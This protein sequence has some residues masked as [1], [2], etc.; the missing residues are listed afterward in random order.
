M[1]EVIL[2]GSS[3]P[4]RRVWFAAIASWLG[5]AQPR[6]GVMTKRRRGCAEDAPRGTA[7]DGLDEEMSYPFDLHPAQAMVMV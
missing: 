2:Q 3:R 1:R 5:G 7:A 4:S 6:L